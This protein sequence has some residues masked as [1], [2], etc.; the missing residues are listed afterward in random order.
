MITKKIT[1]LTLIELT[2]VLG[3]MSIIAVGGHHFYSLHL[4]NQFELAVQTSFN[5]FQCARTTAILQHQTV[6]L[7]IDIQN[8]QLST[9]STNEQL[10]K[11]YTLNQILMSA[12]FFGDSRQVVKFDSLGFSS[13][14]GTLEIS[15]LSKPRRLAKIILQKSG[16]VRI[17]RLPYS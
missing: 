13:T 3:I 17:E 8:T 12:H 7:T 15:S 9:F 2:I 16:R 14:N 4:N 10:L 5:A 1:G 11:T 6:S